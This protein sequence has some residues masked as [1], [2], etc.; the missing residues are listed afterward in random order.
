MTVTGC[1]E[2]ETSKAKSSNEQNQADLQTEKS[3]DEENQSAQTT[4]EDDGSFSAEEGLPPD[5]KGTYSDNPTLIIHEQDGS[6]VEGYLISFTDGVISSHT[7]F[8]ANIKTG[9]LI[10]TQYF[11]GTKNP[12]EGRFSTTDDGIEIEANDLCESGS[13]LYSNRNQTVDEELIARVKANETP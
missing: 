3:V 7:V 8:Q 10:G 5:V 4:T 11:D 6:A 2:E 13:F 1:A 9:N 12:C